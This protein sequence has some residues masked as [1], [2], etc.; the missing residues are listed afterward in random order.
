MSH[1]S[2]K[3]SPIVT[4]GVQILRA[5]RPLLERLTSQGVTIELSEQDQKDLFSFEK[6]VLADLT[7]SDWSYLRIVSGVKATEVAVLTSCLRY[8]RS[9]EQKPTYGQL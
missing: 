8:Y 2:S 9:K 4:E 7:E 5:C 3:P 1:N 6:L